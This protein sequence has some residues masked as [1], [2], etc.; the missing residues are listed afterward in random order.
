[1]AIILIW[2]FFLRKKKAESGFRESP[3]R[4]GGSAL[5]NKPKPPP[6]PT[7]HTTYEYDSLGRRSTGSGLT[8]V[9]KPKTCSPVCRDGYRCVKGEC[10]VSASTTFFDVFTDK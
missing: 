3:T 10:E 1:M 6:P 2:Y 4:S 9:N 5:K 7:P 8:A